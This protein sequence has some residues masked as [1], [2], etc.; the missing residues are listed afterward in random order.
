MTIFAKTPVPSETE[1]QAMPTAKRVDRG[2]RLQRVMERAKNEF[3]KIKSSL[4]SEADE[5]RKA[6]PELSPVHFVGGIGT[7]KVTY[8]GDSL[9]TKKEV[10]EE[11]TLELKDKLPPEVFFR[12]FDVKTI[13]CPVKD[14][15]DRFNKLSTEQQAIV[16]QYFQW[17]PNA[18]AVEFSK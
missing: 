8:K 11:K 4:R 15:K 13:A 12:M 1:I 14:F 9:K 10:D 2:I 18:P 17:C 3:E 5:R 7:A 6:E 16:L